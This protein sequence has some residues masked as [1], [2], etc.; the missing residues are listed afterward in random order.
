M[1]EAQIYQ[2]LTQIFQDTFLDDKL[3]V[4]ADLTAADIPG[5]DSLQ[6]VNILV[7]VEQ[8]FGIKIRSR[9]IDALHT[10]GDLAAVIEHKT[11]A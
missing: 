6:M 3:T 2:E 5:W 7:A 1:Q 11:S 10:V 9:E 4:T 8:K